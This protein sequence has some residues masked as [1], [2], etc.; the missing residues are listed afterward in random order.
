MSAGK[1]F[2]SWRNTLA[3]EIPVGKSLSDSVAQYETQLIRKVL[4]AND[5]NQSQAARQLR[6]PVQT[7]HYKM[8]KLGIE[9]A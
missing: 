3:A 6:I 5:W 8:N 2:R 7:L 1:T 9:K 4:E